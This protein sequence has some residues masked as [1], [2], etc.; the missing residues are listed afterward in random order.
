MD[1]KNSKKVP[2]KVPSST[3]KS[4]P[5]EKKQGNDEIQFK[6][7]MEHRGGYRLIYPS[8]DCSKYE[9]FMSQNQVSLYQETAASQARAQLTRA[10]IDEYNVMIVM[11]YFDNA[12]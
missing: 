11:K 6:W 3:T 9:K 12:A 5:V 10:Q 4:P 1:G 7:E 8:E 2:G